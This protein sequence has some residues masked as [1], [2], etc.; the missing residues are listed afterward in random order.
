MS[1]VIY[2]PAFESSI[3]PGDETDIHAIYEFVLK[4]K[5]PMLVVPVWRNQTAEVT[6]RLYD[7]MVDASYDAAKADSTLQIAL[8]AT[9]KEE[10]VKSLI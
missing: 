7:M 3:T 9:S 8:F 4:N 10:R 2:A 6:N 1:S 5:G